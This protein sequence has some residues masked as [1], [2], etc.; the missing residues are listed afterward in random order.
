MS[1]GWD[2]TDGNLEV[3]RIL[4]YRKVKSL[5][6]LTRQELQSLLSRGAVS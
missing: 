1:T 3:F 6:L 4:T 2:A 5:S